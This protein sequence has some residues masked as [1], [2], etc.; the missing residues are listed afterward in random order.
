MFLHT[1]CAAD[2]NESTDIEVARGDRA[3]ERGADLLKEF[4]RAGV[5]SLSRARLAS[6]QF[7]LGWALCTFASMSGASISTSRSRK[8]AIGASGF[9]YPL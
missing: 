4:L 3:A 5:L 1:S 8:A 6:G 7:E 9:S 2:R